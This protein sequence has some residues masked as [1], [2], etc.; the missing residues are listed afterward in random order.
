M[1]MQ[2]TTDDHIFFYLINEETLEPIHENVINNYM[3][4]S[5]IVF[6][7]SSKE[8]YCLTYRSNRRSFEIF[9][10]KHNHSFKGMVIDEDLDKSLGVEM[11]RQG[12]LLVSKK[13]TVMIIDSVTYKEKY[14]FSISLMDQQEEEREPNQIIAMRLCQNE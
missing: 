5:S 14:R 2:L 8:R 9:R 12:A 11:I 7:Q 13:D 4:C 3:R 6:G 10:K 1:R